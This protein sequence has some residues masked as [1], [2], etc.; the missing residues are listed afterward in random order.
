MNLHSQTFVVQR[1]TVH[2]TW[3]SKFILIEEFK[4]EVEK[5]NTGGHFLGEK[6]AKV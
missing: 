4:L 6:K 1:L 2:S 5:C 3:G